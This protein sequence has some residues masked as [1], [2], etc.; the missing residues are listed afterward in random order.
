MFE[1]GKIAGI[2]GWSSARIIGFTFGRI[3]FSGAESRLG[4]QTP[5]PLAHVSIALFRVRC[6]ECG[7]EHVYKPSEVLRSDQEPAESFTPH[8]LFR[9]TTPDMGQ[10]RSNSSRTCGA[11]K[12]RL[13]FPLL[14]S[15][16]PSYSQGVEVIHLDI[17][18]IARLA[19]FSGTTS[20]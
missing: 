6:D 13:P 19:D 4:R 7:K 18:A 16:S 17:R 14:Q 2:F 1:C 10:Q 11:R 8:P 5:L 9:D 15:L 3:Y 20:V 12:S